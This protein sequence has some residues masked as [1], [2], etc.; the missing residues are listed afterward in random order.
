MQNADVSRFT[1]R[2]GAVWSEAH[3]VLKDSGVLAFTYHHSR[4][5][6]WLSVLF[7][8]IN[9]GFG[10]TA[11]HPVKAEMSV[12]MPKHQA[13]EPIELDVILVCR[14]QS[15]LERSEWNGDSWYTVTESAAQQVQRL[16]SSGR[17]LSRNDIRVIVMAQLLR[18]LSVSHCLETA[19]PLLEPGGAEIESTITKLHGKRSDAG[20]G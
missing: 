18:R 20:K 13:K 7:A 2:L 4:S 11:V 14:K 15:Q 6:G 12:A 1:D 3:R 10:I 16:R 5:E 19:L 17:R 9:A 8:L